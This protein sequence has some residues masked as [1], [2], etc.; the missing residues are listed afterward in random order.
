MLCPPGY[1]RSVNCSRC[2]Q[3]SDGWHKSTDD[4]SLN[5]A[6]FCRQNYQCNEDGQHVASTDKINGTVCVCRTGYFLYDLDFD[7]HPQCKRCH[8]CDDV[9][10]TV[11][12]GC[13]TNTIS[14]A[15]CRSGTKTSNCRGSPTPTSLSTT[16]EVTTEMV[17]TDSILSTSPYEAVITNTTMAMTTTE[18]VSHS[19]H[20]SHSMAVF[21]MDAFRLLP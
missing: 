13:Q 18:I 11:E 6:T 16:T 20:P 2:V 19:Q 10:S 8:C 15:Y 7:G 14:G 12:Q 17:T 5:F 9:H 21:H 3:C 4:Q 1:V